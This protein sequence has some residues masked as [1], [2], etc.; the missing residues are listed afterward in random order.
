MSKKM[1]KEYLRFLDEF[2]KSVETDTPMEPRPQVD[3]KIM[4]EAHKRKFKKYPVITGQ[5]WNEDGGYHIDKV[6][7]AIQ[8]GIPY[9]EDPPADR[10]VF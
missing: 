3:R 7:E 4:F 1:S 6:V 2:I 5:H 8:S 10:E 9:A